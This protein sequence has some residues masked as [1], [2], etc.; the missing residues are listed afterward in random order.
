V[1][2]GRVFADGPENPFRITAPLGV[3]R[4]VADP[5]ETILSSPR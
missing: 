4:I 2:L 3:K 5:E 1:F